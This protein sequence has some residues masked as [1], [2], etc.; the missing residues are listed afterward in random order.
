M[1]ISLDWLGDFIDWKETDVQTIADRLT[2]ATAEVEAVQ[3]QGALLEH[4]CVGKIL[5]VSKHS[6]ADKLSIAEVETDKGMKRVVC[7]GTNLKEGM[8]VA[9]AHVGATVKWHGG[10]LMTLAP[11]K[12]RGEASEGMICA[13]EELELEGML[14][15]LPEDG[16]RPIVNLSRLTAQ[17]SQ[18]KAGQP[19]REALGLTDTILLFSN[20]ALTN[21]PDLF[22]H[23]GFA[24]ECVALGLAAWKK[25][26][27]AS[28]KITFPKASKEAY[29]IDLTMKD[30]VPAYASCA[31]RV[32]GIGETPEWMKKRLAAMGNR[33][34]SLPVDITNYVMWECGMPMHAFDR[35]EIQGT[36][37]KFR[38]S[39]AGEKLKTLDGQEHTLPEGAIVLED[40]AGLFDLCGIMGGAR[41][42]S[43][44]AMKEMYLHAPVYDPTRIRKAVQALNHRTDAATIF[45][46]GVPL[47]SA[48]DGLLRALKLFMDLCPGAKIA[49]SLT[50]FG[51]KRS[52][53]PIEISLARLQSTVG[54]ELTAKEV[55]SILESLECEVKAKKS[56]QP[57]SRPRPA[58][59]DAV[60]SVLPPAH[61]ARD[62]R[63][64]ADLTDEVARVYGYDRIP[65]HMPL[66]PM[67]IP[68][69]DDRIHR[70]REALKGDGF[71]EI[72]PLSLLGAQLLEKCGMNP[73]EAVRIANPLGEDMALMQTSTLPGLLEHA[74]KNLLL[75]QGSLKTFHWG[76][77]FHAK[78][79]EHTELSLLHAAKAETGLHDDPFLVLKQTVTNALKEAGYEASFAQAKDHPAYAHP[80]RFASLSVNGKEIGCVF[81][82][83]PSV[84]G[85]FG[86]D[87]R[88]AAATLDLTTLL[89]IS[90]N[91]RTAKPVAQFPAISYDV[92]LPWNHE[93][94][95][96]GL[97][98]T[99][100]E[101]SALLE[102]VAVADLYHGKQH[103][104]KEY[105]LT[106]RFTYRAADRTLTEDEAKREHE[107][108]LQSI[109]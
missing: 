44:A 99:L 109:A 18:L 62:L 8:L 54:L 66:A 72:L 68:E 84:R 5:S 36:H 91:E 14:R 17:S 65:E 71:L 74:E 28:P 101:K 12:I 23:I 102:Q 45:E 88:S 59:K 80:G 79:P 100:R 104:P 27:P 19:L 37:L 47:S 52:T 35:N 89:A 20:T 60:F 107:K 81:E 108:L 32:D 1:K 50:L 13:A 31:V 34:I 85:R 21:R 57:S 97:L 56:A 90:P 78:K 92:T 10:E 76:H 43:N 6:N 82:L 61:R 63:I 77:V 53:K 22:S 9:F 106:L 26:Q 103:Q 105:N 30:L 15:P 70:V 58:G 86:L 46:K 3:R 95:V 16:E 49:S 83:H 40:S 87:H 7:G 4:C 11:V 94:H 67:G 98:K 33:S 96:G 48:E 25:G 51:E 75:S 69:R 24:R 29:A 42:A 93:K 39:A 38:E 73:S 64:A 41:S 55:T 2:L